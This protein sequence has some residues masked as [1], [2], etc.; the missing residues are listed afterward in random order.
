VE[1]AL[2][3]HRILSFCCVCVV[4][5]KWLV[6]GNECEQG[7]REMVVVVEART[8]ISYSGRS[9]SAIPTRE[10]YPVSSSKQEGRL[11]VYLFSNVI[12]Q[13]HS[14]PYTRRRINSKIVAT[15]TSKRMF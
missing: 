6:E 7:P 4:I 11:F 13:M 3:G 8:V 2:H 1:Y 12:V 9:R 10:L 5:R 15:K 14:L